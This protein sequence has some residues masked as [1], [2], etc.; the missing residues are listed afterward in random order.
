MKL[1]TEISFPTLKHRLNYKRKSVFSG[2]CFSENIGGWLA[3]L[4]FDTQVNPCG[5]AYNPVS[6]AR[7]IAVALSGKEITESE[8][9][10]TRNHYAH[11][12]FHSVF[13]HNDPGKTASQINLALRQY[14]DALLNADFLFLTFGTAIGFEFAASGHIVNNCHH[15]PADEFSKQMLDESICTIEIEAALNQLR[16]KN[17]KIQ[18]WF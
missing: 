11:P 2:S 15:L 4:K 12:D 17:P 13:N 18:F 16:E 10:Q 8:L 6:I 1:T 7:H 3:D 9:V 5:I 14:R